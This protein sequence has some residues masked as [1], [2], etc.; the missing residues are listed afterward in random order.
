MKRHDEEE[1]DV[2]EL[3]VELGDEE[4]D[5]EQIEFGNVMLQES[6]VFRLVSPSD[7]SPSLFELFELE[8]EVTVVVVLLVLFVEADFIMFRFCS[9]AREVKLSS[10]M[11]FDPSDD[12]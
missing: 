10:K 7:D 12:T 1:E 5:N 9:H 6:L 3:S 8:D 11:Q 2:V 4:L